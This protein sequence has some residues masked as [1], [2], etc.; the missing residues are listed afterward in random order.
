MMMTPEKHL[1]NI[2]EEWNKTDGYSISPE[3]NDALTLAEEDFD[4]VEA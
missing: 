2:L 3:M 1:A 4:G